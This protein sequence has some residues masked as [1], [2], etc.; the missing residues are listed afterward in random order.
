[1]PIHGSANRNLRDK[2]FEKREVSMY[3]KYEEIVIKYRCMFCTSD[4]VLFAS[5]GRMFALVYGNFIDDTIM[6]PPFG[7]QCKHCGT[8]YKV[9]GLNKW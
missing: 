2:G 7:V 4:E 8:V 3:L 6:N 5:Q 9:S 1:M